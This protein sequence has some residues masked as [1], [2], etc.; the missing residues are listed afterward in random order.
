MKL[1]D[2]HVSIKSENRL[3]KGDAE[4]EWAVDGGGEFSFLGFLRTE[5]WGGSW[6]TE[7][8]PQPSRCLPTLS[9][10]CYFAERETWLQPPGQAGT[11]K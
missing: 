8:E 11:L 2:H 10:W 1:Y 9:S 6:A 4:K 7:Q 5:E 3:Q